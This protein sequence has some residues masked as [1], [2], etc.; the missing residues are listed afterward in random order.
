MAI[1]RSRKLVGF[2]PLDDELP[3]HGRKQQYLL[4]TDDGGEAPHT[5]YN[6]G[7]VIVISFTSV[8]ALVF[9]LFWGPGVCLYVMNVGAQDDPHVSCMVRVHPKIGPEQE[10]SLYARIRE[11]DTSLARAILTVTRAG[12]NLAAQGF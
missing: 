11:E 9:R 8:P 5:V 12:M 1:G 10:R 6:V 3:S 7:P 2:I 4:K